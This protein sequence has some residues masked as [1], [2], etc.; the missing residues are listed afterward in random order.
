MNCNAIYPISYLGYW[1]ELL[2][3]IEKFSFFTAVSSAEFNLF[4]RLNKHLSLRMN[5]FLFVSVCRNDEIIL[6]QYIQ[7]W[8][9]HN[10]D[11]RRDWTSRRWI[12][13]VAGKML[14]S[15]G[16][17]KNAHGLVSISDSVHCA[18]C[19][20]LLQRWQYLQQFN[21]DRGK[22]IPYYYKFTTTLVIEVLQ[23]NRI[24]S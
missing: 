10:N 6:Y 12:W 16:T 24:S 13:M 8:S 9:S 15:H 19:D 18:R 17:I 7:C 4:N 5:N 23:M 20:F 11:K 22:Q 21:L 1:G 3:I 2:G 14:L